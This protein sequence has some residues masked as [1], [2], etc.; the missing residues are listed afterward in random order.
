VTFTTPMTT[1]WL[2]SSVLSAQ[3]STSGGGVVSGS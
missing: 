2:R 1:G 3:R